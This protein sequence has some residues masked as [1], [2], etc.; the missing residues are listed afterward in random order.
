MKRYNKLVRDK[1]VAGI[2]K[3]GGKVR[4]HVATRTEYGK[5][6]KEKLREEVEEFLRSED[7]EEM[8]DI[9]EVV[10]AIRIHLG[11]SKGA[12]ERTR[13]KKGR[14]KGRFKKRIILD[15]A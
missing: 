1:I 3:K 9:L 2:L 5:K 7:H 15:W 13:V 12:I 6:L 8:A 11:F 10:E 4:S 14:V